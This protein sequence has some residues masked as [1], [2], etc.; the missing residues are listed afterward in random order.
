MFKFSQ[1]LCFRVLCFIAIGNQY[2]CIEYALPWSLHSWTRFV[3]GY[4]EK[5][6]VHKENIHSIFY[7]HQ[8]TGEWPISYKPESKFEVPC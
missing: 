3:N 5:Q 1:P 4:W 7:M 6:R 8:D 2:T